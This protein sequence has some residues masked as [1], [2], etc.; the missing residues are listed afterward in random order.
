M[1]KT[2]TIYL[3]TF[4]LIVLL[5][6]LSK[7]ASSQ[8]GGWSQQMTNMGVDNL[9]CVQAFSPLNVIASVGYYTYPLMNAYQFYK[10]TNGGLNWTLI[11][12]G[13]N[14]YINT[15]QFID[16]LTGYAG[17]GYTG[18]PPDFDKGKFI[19]KTTNGGVNWT[20]VS[21][22]IITAMP[23]DM[24]YTDLYFINSNTGWAC[25]NDGQIS[26]T[27]NGGTNF[28]IHAMTPYFKKKAIY[29][30]NSQTGWTAGE[31][32]KIANTSNGG[33]NWN[34]QPD[35]MT[36]DIN[37]LY[38]LNG[39]TGYACNSAGF[40]FKTTNSGVNW[41]NNWITTTSMNSIFY[42]DENHGW[43]A[44]TTYIMGYNGM[45]FQSYSNSSMTLKSISFSDTLHGW[46]CGGTFMLYTSTGGVTGISPNNNS[47]PVEYNLEQ[48]YPNP[49][50]PYTIIS[51]DLPK[52]GIVKLAIFDFLGREV[53]KLVANEFTNAGRYSVVFN[54]SN[55][56]SGLYFYVLEVNNGKDFNMVRKMVMIK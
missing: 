8:Q 18:P 47:I 1:M 23:S 41:N 27:T 35:L 56:S 53:T 25:A 5:L 28:T 7:T 38:F 9:T 11:S 2:T 20:T 54:G 26:K 50:N 36:Q 16:E 34:M 44:G 29:F 32:G 31:S 22:L 45:F 42:K 3:T 33:L 30:V 15:F 12:S 17:G 48:N 43:I 6:I 49:F 51:Y 46:A 37:S 40:L 39:Q 24:D 4:I 19:L 21:Y 13:S 10:T 14:C 52:N 55:L